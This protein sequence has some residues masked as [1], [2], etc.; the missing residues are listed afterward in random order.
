MIELLEFISRDFWTFCGVVL[1]L[2]MFAR[3]IAFIWNRFWKHWNIRIHGYP[4]IHCD[5][6][7]DFSQS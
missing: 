5:D 1:L 6:D 2:N 3:F 4:S 7:G